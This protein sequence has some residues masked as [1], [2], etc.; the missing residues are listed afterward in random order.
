MASEELGGRLR[1]VRKMREWSLRD[2]AEKADISPAYLQKLERGQVQKPSPHVLHSLAEQLRVP[3]SN[4]MQLAGYVVPND[5]ADRAALPNINTLAYALS[6]E[7]LTDDEA[8]A[9]ARYLSWYRSQQT[10]NT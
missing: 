7:D 5:S 6:S 3:Y 1:Q 9:L 2:L 8:E 10:T 4:L